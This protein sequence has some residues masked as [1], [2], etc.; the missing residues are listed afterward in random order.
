MARVADQKEK[1][2]MGLGSTRRKGTRERSA[3]SKGKRGEG[4]EGVGE[5]RRATDGGRERVLEGVLASGEGSKDSLGDA[6]AL[7]SFS[8]ILQEFGDLTLF[9][10]RRSTD[11]QMGRGVQQKQVSVVGRSRQERGRGKC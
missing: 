3:E 6:V 4:Q 1:W 2:E 10:N 11:A 5:G 8:D 7:H 9:P